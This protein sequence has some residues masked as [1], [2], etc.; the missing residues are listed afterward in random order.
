[1]LSSKNNPVNCVTFD[2]DHSVYIRFS[3]VCIFRL[4]V[5][6]LIFSFITLNFAH[7]CCLRSFF[8]LSFKH[9][10]ICLSIYFQFILS[11]C[12]YHISCCLYFFNYVLL[13]IYHVYMASSLNFYER[14][15]L[16]CW[17]IRNKEDKAIILLLFKV[18]MNL[19]CCW[20]F[21]VCLLCVS[22][23]IYSLV[24]FFIFNFSYPD[25]VL[26]ILCL[27]RWNF[28]NDQF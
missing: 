22:I 20:Q 7:P 9:F 25:F 6:M 16:N 28:N 12:P 15:I 23:N 14:H 13:A 17:V 19:Q 8:C 26:F 21:C 2:D 1:M 5:F 4:L 11:T 10:I 24:P 3:G 27:I 18:L